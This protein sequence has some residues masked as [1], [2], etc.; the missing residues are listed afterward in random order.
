L[1]QIQETLYGQWNYIKVE[2][3]S[4]PEEN[5]TEEELLE[6]VPSISFTADHNLTIMWGG[7][8]LSYGKYRIEGNLIRYTEN[9]G[10]GRTREFPFLVSK[11]TD[12][13]L[14]FETMEQNATRVTA[15]RK[16]T[17]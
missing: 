4:N 15:V 17:K 6:Q 16:S 14:V 12:K 11:L 3:P 5:L 13:E 8:R 9:L 2:S 10:G 1:H 7:K